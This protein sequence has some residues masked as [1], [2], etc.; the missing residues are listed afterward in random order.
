MTYA[1][2]K[3]FINQMNKLK[4]AELIEILIDEEAV[5]SQLTKKLNKKENY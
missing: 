4:K 2:R 1:E 3:D 5:I